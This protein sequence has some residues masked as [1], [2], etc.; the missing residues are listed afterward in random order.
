MFVIEESVTKILN[1][2]K[3]RNTDEKSRMIV[4]NKKRQSAEPFT[5]AYGYFCVQI[6]EES[7]VHEQR[8]EEDAGA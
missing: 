7:I 4:Y 1:L 5:V 2:R 6:V 8:R 3:L